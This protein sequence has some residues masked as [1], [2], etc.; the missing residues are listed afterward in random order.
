MSGGEFFILV[1]G[2]CLLW[3]VVRY[4]GFNPNWLRP[5]VGDSERFIAEQKTAAAGRV[6]DYHP[7]VT[8]KAKVSVVATGE[9]AASAGAQAYVERMTRHPV[10]LAIMPMLEQS[11]F[12]SAR[13]YLQ[14]I[15][16]GLP[17]ATQQEKDDFTAVMSAFAT[18]DPMYQNCMASILP[19]VAQNPNGLKQTLLYPHMAAAPDAEHARYVLYFADELGAV[20]RVKKGNSYIVFPVGQEP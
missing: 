3:L 11:D 17:K 8:A 1:T 16:Y 5:L 20:R 10:L 6:A 15:A 12:D 18:V 19:I 14:K 4:L 13:R 2:V 9:N 7:P